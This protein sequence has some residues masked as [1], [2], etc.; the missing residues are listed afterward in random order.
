VAG[1]FF[2]HWTEQFFSILVA[3]GQ[4]LRRRKAAVVGAKFY[5]Y[6]QFSLDSLLKHEAYRSG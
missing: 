6:F 4:A 5:S 1:K 2:L 3:N